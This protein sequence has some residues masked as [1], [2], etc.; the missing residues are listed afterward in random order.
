MKV[1][2]W[3]AWC[4]AVAGPSAT[5]RGSAS[6]ALT[7]HRRADR[8]QC[9]NV[10]FHGIG[11]PTHALAP[12]EGEVWVD[13]GVLEAVLDAAAQRD[14][15]RITLDDGNASD[16]ELVLP[17]LQA[18]GL[19]ATFF[20]VAGRLADPGYLSADD[21]RRLDGAGMTIGNHGMHHRSWRSLDDAGLLEEL[22]TAR[23]VLEDVVQRP[24]DQAAIPFGAYDRRV[25]SALR[26]SGYRRVF[27]SDG[28]PARADRWLQARS[29]LHRSDRWPEIEQLL[30]PTAS[31]PARAVRCAKLA[32]KRWR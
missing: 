14:H 32:V 8:G 12:G 30:A 3:R 16:I 6:A 22:V 11:T 18:R 1:S 4:V 7:G 25:L 26:R 20:V 24:V 29:S 17:A 23:A 10:T 19:T 31:A 13:A 9:V 27:T 5:L 2:G 28:G 21:L 15:V